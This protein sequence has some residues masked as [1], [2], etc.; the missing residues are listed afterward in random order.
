MKQQLTD[1]NYKATANCWVQAMMDKNKK[2]P[3][4]SI[5]NIQRTMMF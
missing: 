2:K 3:A 1:Y 5:E 4:R